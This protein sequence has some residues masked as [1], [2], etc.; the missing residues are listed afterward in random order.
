MTAAPTAGNYVKG[1]I[2]W[3]SDPS[4]VA[5]T[6]SDYVIVGWICTASG[7]PGTW[8]E[9]RVLVEGITVPTVVAASPITA[10]LGADVA[11]NNTANYFDGPSVAQGSTGTWFVSG[12][13]TLF[14]TASAVFDVKLWDGTTVIASSRCHSTGAQSMTLSL[15]GYI[16]SPAGNLRMSAKDSTNT[17]GQIQFNVTGNSK[18]STITAFRIA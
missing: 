3:N 7:T 9:M 12:T 18:D 5:D 17:S 8:K 1:D 13:V 14:D 15:S 4:A 2:V 16:A 10:S 11:L 6:Q